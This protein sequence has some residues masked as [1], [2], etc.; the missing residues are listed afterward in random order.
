LNYVAAGLGV[1]ILPEQFSRLRTVGV[2]FIPLSAPVPRY[3]YCAAWLP[4]NA[5]SSLGHF[6][7]IAQSAAES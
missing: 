6:L 7:T 2:S 4:D 3:R 1:T 5:R